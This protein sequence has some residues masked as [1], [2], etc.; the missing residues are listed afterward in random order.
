ML[1]IEMLVELAELST[2][3]S[4]KP[5]LVENIAKEGSNV[6]PVIHHTDIT[7]DLSVTKCSTNGRL[8]EP[9]IFHGIAPH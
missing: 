7:P 3:A 8:F 4:D 2:L 9:L 6:L 5:K 1:W